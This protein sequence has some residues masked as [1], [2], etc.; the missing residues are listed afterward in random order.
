MSANHFSA[1]GNVKSKSL[2]DGEQ[3]WHEQFC[4]THRC[5]QGGFS[6]VAF[7]EHCSTGDIG[8]GDHDHADSE[9]G[10]AIPDDDT[11]SLAG[12]SFESV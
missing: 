12:F 4:Q 9:T 5:D 3:L 1:D 10:T 2:C 6:L 8:P 7:T 11:A